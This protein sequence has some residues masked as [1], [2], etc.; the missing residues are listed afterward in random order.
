M[1]EERTWNVSTWPRKEQGSG[2]LM[3]PIWLTIFWKIYIQMV[4]NFRSPHALA[5][6]FRNKKYKSPHDLLK[7]AE[8]TYETELELL[9]PFNVYSGIQTLNSEHWDWVEGD[10]QRGTGLRKAVMIYEVIIWSSTKITARNW[11]CALDMTPHISASQQAFRL[12]KI[13]CSFSG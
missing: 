7:T 8:K 3:W 13:S 1:R 4:P 5:K 12:F 11:R 6:I 10:S 9:G 2:V